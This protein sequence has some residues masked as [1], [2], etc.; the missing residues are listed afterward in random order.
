MP[1]ATTP[2]RGKGVA[3]PP[4]LPAAPTFVSLRSAAALWDLLPPASG[5]VEVTAAGTGDK[6]KRQGICLHR[7][8]TLVAG[9][10]TRHRGIPITTPAR[11]IADLRIAAAHKNRQVPVGAGEPT[12]TASIVD[13]RPSRTIEPVT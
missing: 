13:G 1:S 4:P 6:G 12:A 5:P 7:S 9:L 8:R 11:T 10:T 2:S 3:W